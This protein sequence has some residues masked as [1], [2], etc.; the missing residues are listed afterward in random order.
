MNVYLHADDIG[1]SKAISRN[2]L[3]CS[4]V[5]NSVSVITTGDDFIELN[6]LTILNQK[7]R[8]LSCHLNILE[9]KPLTNSNEIPLLV[10]LN[11]Y[12]NNTFSKLMFGYIFSSKYNKQRLIDQISLEFKNQILHYI[13]VCNPKE[14]RLD[15]HQ[16]IHLL[17]YIFKLIL[18]LNF[19]IS[20]IRLPYEKF[21]FDI[22]IIKKYPQNYIKWIVLNLLSVYCKRFYLKKTNIKFTDFLIGVLGSGCM[23]IRLLKKFI[24]RLP[25]SLSSSMNI[26]LLFHPGGSNESE[27]HLWANVP[28]FFNFYISNDRLVEKNMLNEY[29]SYILSIN[30]NLRTIDSMS[31]L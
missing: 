22:E 14:I 1:S 3:D 30:S 15:S 29:S 17:P 16:H 24:N 13:K 12:F 19:P 26:E 18:N 5:L 6:R 7:F 28:R 20:Y 21:T 25:S 10:D 8:F 31:N 23:N 9:G 11:G 4:G 27:R 2:I